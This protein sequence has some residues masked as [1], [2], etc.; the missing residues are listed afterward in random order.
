MISVN[1]CFVLRTI[2][3]V[4]ILVPR[5]ANP[6]GNDFYYL[7]STGAFLWDVVSKNSY[8]KEII[9]SK[10]I[11]AYNINGDKEACDSLIQ[12]IEKLIHTGL[13]IEAR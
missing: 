6:V 13:I 7:N 9:I 3:N 2:E 12:F 11:E 10:M 4:H 8:T 5:K 1:D